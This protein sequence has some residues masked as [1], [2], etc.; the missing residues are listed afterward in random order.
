MNSNLNFYT[1]ISTPSRP[2]KKVKRSAVDD[3]TSSDDEPDTNGHLQPNG[4]RKRRRVDDEE[5]TEHKVPGDSIFPTSTYPE[6]DTAPLRTIEN[7]RDDAEQ[8]WRKE[9]RAWTMAEKATTNA[10]RERYR[11]EAL[12]LH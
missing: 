3:E 9:Q 10:D 6:K 4:V 2:N 12:A 5:E 8:F 11:L 1:P 7:A